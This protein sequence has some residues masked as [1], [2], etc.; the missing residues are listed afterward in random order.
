MKGKSMTVETKQ[1]QFLPVVTEAQFKK[2]GQR[3]KAL[4]IA[5]D[6]IAQLDAARFQPKM[7]SWLDI[8]N[9][10]KH[11]ENMFDIDVDFDPDLQ[12]FATSPECTE[13]SCYACALG[14]TLLSYARI[15]DNFDL[16][17]K[18]EISDINELIE[19][20]IFG[21][22][23][24]LIEHAFEKGCG[25]ASFYEADEDDE[26]GIAEFEW[27]GS[28]FVNEDFDYQVHIEEAFPAARKFGNQYVS[29]DVRL[30]AI[31]Q[32]IIDNKGRFKPW[33]K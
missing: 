16:S 24:Y 26:D 13:Q 30:R 29:D 12:S 28:I 9:A 27:D 23:V 31:M 19:E 11:Y 20:E 6:I 5:R 15:N 8:T 1:E 7:G 22:D 32:N 2:L 21:D 10:N 3:G 14:A 17:H 4:A 33:K 18:Y 25:A